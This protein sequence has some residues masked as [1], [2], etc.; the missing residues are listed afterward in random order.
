MRFAINEVSGSWRYYHY[1]GNSTQN[2][3]SSGQDPRK[4]LNSSRGLF[5]SVYS[6]LAYS[7]STPVLMLCHCAVTRATPACAWFGFTIVPSWD[8]NETWMDVIMYE[9]SAG[10]WVSQEARTVGITVHAWMEL[11]V[12]VKYSGSFINDWIGL[13]KAACGIHPTSGEGVRRAGA[14]T[15]VKR[16]APDIDFCDAPA[17]QGTPRL[18]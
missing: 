7:F 5:L 3:W 16:C 15:F 10:D 11:H 6:K 4:L 2:E 13:R 12:R 14:W 9:N 8:N 1:Y 18:K 17:L